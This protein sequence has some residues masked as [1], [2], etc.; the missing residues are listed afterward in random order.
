MYETNQD[1]PAYKHLV[2][3][4]HNRKQKEQNKRL[5]TKNTLDSKRTKSTVKMPYSINTQIFFSREGNK[6]K[7]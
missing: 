1:R 2:Q 5:K 7:I 4:V 6:V 3:N